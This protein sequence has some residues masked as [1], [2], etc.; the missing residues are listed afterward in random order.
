[1]NDSNS[2]PQRPAVESPVQGGLV[3]AQGVDLDHFQPLD[4]QVLAWTTDDGAG[5]KFV[6][7]RGLPIIDVVLRFKA[8]TTQETVH[9][10]LAALTFYM[11]DEGSQQHTSTRQAEQLERLGAILEQKLSLDHA[12]LSF[13][14]LST[15]GVFDPALELLIDFVARPSFTAGALAKIKSELLQH[16]ASR[17]QHPRLRARSEAFRH[18]FKGHQYGNPSGINQQGIDQTTLADLRRF[19]QRAYCA[20]NLNMVIVGDL[21]LAQA[22]AVSQRI[23]Q[24]LPQGWSAIEPPAAVPAAGTTLNVEQPGASNAILLAIPMN[25]PAND[26]EYPALVLASEVLGAGIESRLMKAL[27][28]R[29]GLT[30]D[31]FTR[32]KALSAGGLFTA[33]WDI[34]PW[35]VEGSQAL[36]EALLREFIDQGPTQ[37]E[38]QLARKQLA[39]RLLR[40]VAQ[41]KNLAALL[42]EI[43]D[44]RQPAD[45]LDNYIERLARLTPDDIRAVMQRRLDPG[46]TV[47]VSVGPR[48]EQQPLPAL[49]Q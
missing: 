9:A 41:N 46:R 47:R 36:V 48:A 11:L 38:L 24:S 44:Q 4:T 45:F 37:A 10:G 14:S 34:A 1:M 6:E 29:R 23:S 20:S 25:V 30:Y 35:H 19:H 18:L 22:Q 15:S 31:V 40:N 17:E 43:T 32:L 16:N 27:R 3:S 21:S 2:Y 8:G 5:V 49:D 13:R 26:P 28:H 7:A 42:T 12:T 33:E 39:G